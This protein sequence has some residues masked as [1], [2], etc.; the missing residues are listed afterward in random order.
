VGNFTE[1]RLISAVETNLL[2][3]VF[4]V[5]WALNRSSDG[6][7]K[8]RAFPTHARGQQAEVKLIWILNSPTLRDCGKSKNRQREVK[9][10][11]SLPTCLLYA[12]LNTPEL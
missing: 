11:Y 2:T 7:T 9:S 3:D 6:Q 8:D 10:K 5:L 12:F 4:N 1:F